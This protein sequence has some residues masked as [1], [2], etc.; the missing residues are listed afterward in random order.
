MCCWK[1]KKLLILSFALPWLAACQ[2]IGTVGFDPMS[3]TVSEGASSATITVK[4]N[5]KSSGVVTVD[6]LTTDGSAVAGSDYTAVSGTLTWPDGDSADR[7]ISVPIIDDALAEGQETL[8]LTL[9]NV[10]GAQLGGS[11]ATITIEDDDSP[12]VTLNKGQATR[13]EQVVATLSGASAAGATVTVAG[14]AAAVSSSSDNEITFTVPSAS[15]AG[16]QP[17]EVRVGQLTLS[18]TLKVL[19]DVLPG[20]AS[21]VL[22]PGFTQ[23][24]LQGELAKLGF[25][26]EES[27]QPLGGSESVC[28]GQLAEID[29]GGT[30]IGEALEE[31]KAL[32]KNGQALAMQVDPRT[33]YDVGSVDHLGAVGA[34]QAHARGRSGAGVVI[35]VLDSGVNAH[36][37][38]AGR[39]LFSQG[40][41]FV[42]NDPI[43]NDDYQ[44]NSDGHGTP[45]AVLAAG[46]NSGV[47][48]GASILPVKV[49][50]GNGTCLSSDVIRGIC[51]TLT[52]AGDL[53]RLVL[54]LS[55][56]GD[57]P[58]DALEALIDY[59]LSKGVLVAAAAGNQGEVGSPTH[60]PAAFDRPGL[61]AVAALQASPLSCVDFEQQ[62]LG[63]NFKV[64]DQF[65]DAG[66]PIAVQT[67]FF[68]NGNPFGG[69]FTSIENGGLAGGIGQ[70]VQVNN[71]N[72]NFGFPYP[73]EGINLSYGEYGGNL[74][75]AVNGDFLNV[76]SI[77]AL[78]GTT[79][80]G[81]AITV[82]PDI[83]PLS[84]LPLDTGALRLSG[85]IDSF[86][87]G[88]QELWLDDVCPS[89]D[90]A[91]EPAPFSTRGAYLDVA[92]PGV[93]LRSGTPAG[94]YASYEGTS[95]A[96][97]LVAG[98][99]ALWREA[100]PAASPADIAADLKG[101]A[102]LL[103]TPTGP[104]YLESEVGKGLLDLSTLP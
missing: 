92:A 14:I 28:G 70:D 46:S 18:A 19:G 32:E 87:L 99:L 55:L 34:Y 51:H 10:Q 81:V 23:A 85:Q 44:L 68:G 4:R 39:I 91:W 65:S 29:V 25:V 79:P 78:A 89:E 40:Y 13:Q 48:P 17:V 60:Y 30:P 94:G 2:L 21:L 35:A 12:S 43:P 38:L 86:A 27:L 20:K 93:D 33:G 61:L 63:T 64:G 58:V 5:G 52:H 100:K 37:E 95:F 62:K 104:P 66:V 45:I 97:P 47:A 102:R 24:D 98:A 50:D 26:L 22:A 36:G 88:G 41:D 71:V 3:F 75:L 59:A 16:P 54:N 80:S 103:F 11:Q 72:L 49:C 76:G 56:G 67:F 53:Q 7:S 96:T 90:D 101:S 15:A 8:M 42:N 77:G 83:D 69:G 57:T 1:W 9:S 6:Y 82:T 84:Q 74:N 31:L 73:L